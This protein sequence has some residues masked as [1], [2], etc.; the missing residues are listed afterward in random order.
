MKQLCTRMGDICRITTNNKVRNFVAQFAEYCKNLSRRAGDMSEGNN[1]TDFSQQQISLLCGSWVADDSGIKGID[2]F[3]NTVE[4]LSHPIYPLRLLKNI[5][6]K[7]E[8]VELCWYRGNNKESS[9]IFQKSM[10]ANASNIVNLANYGIAVN[11]ENAKYLV[12]FL[13]DVESKNYDRLEHDFSVG[14]LG[15]IDGYGFSPYIENLKFDGEDAFA[16]RFAAIQ[17]KGFRDEW[18]A[19]MKS[20]REKESEIIRIVFAASLASCLVKPA[21]IMPFVVHLW[22]RGGTGKT[23][24]MMVGGSIWGNPEIGKYIKTFDSTEVGKE[25][26]AVFLN[27]MPLMLDELQILSGKNGKDGLRRMIY[28]LTEGVGRERGR[29]EGGLQRAGT[30]RNT[31][32]TTGE[33]PLIEPFWTEGAKYRTIEINCTGIRFFENGNY[34]GNSAK[35]VAGFIQK[36]YGFFGR[37]FIERLEAEGVDCFHDLHDRFTEEIKAAGDIDGKQAL[38]AA[39]ILTAD[40]LAEQWIFKDGIRLT[41]KDIMPHLITKG[42]ADQDRSALEHLQEAA[43]IYRAHFDP[44]QAEQKNTEIWGEFK[45]KDGKDYVAFYPSRFNALL[46]DSGYHSGKFVEWAKKNNYLRIGRD[47]KTT[48]KT[49]ITGM[50]K[51]QRC[52]WLLLPEGNIAEDDEDELEYIP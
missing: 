28:Q 42:E 9:W 45:E 31:I 43:S 34:V 26:G 30:W 25:L 6:T 32:I 46:E 41:V 50:E 44:K 21:G 16:D 11:S 52:F 8:K 13:S 7:L 4:A 3:G 10:I 47:G 27:S 5:D 1:S 17:P 37:E 19:A 2:K 35:E 49:R 51:P 39:L 22:G 15:W 18:M 40:T 36:H 33:Y 24:V 29:K 14:R 38:S 12:R 23:V 20:F 48:I